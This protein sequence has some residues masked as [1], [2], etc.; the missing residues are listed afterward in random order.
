[1]L[2]GTASQKS[3]SQQT[4]CLVRGEERLGFDY[5]CYSDIMRKNNCNESLHFVRYFAD[6]GVNHNQEFYRSPRFCCRE[7]TTPLILTS[8]KNDNYKQQNLLTVYLSLSSFCEADR[9]KIHIQNEIVFV[10]TLL[11]CV[12]TMQYVTNYEEQFITSFFNT[13]IMQAAVRKKII[14]PKF[15]VSNTRLALIW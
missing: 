15:F 4:R 12:C 10:N 14:C 3:V 9:K 11:Q 1:M 7:Q 5:Q 13:N 6:D 8:A 2:K